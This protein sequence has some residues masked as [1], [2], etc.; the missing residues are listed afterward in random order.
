[1]IYQYDQALQLP[2]VDL[3]D[4]QMMAMALNAAKDMYERGEQQIK[5]F[6]K[7]YGDFLT[8][9]TADQNWWNQNVTGK[10]RDT[11]NSI[12]ARGGDPL[13]NARDRAQLSMMIN[14]MPYGDM[15]FKRQRAENAKEY[16]KNMATLRMNDKYNK[17]FSM[18]LQED[19]NQWALDSAG[20]TS[21]TVFSDLNTKTSH[22]FDGVNRK[23]Y[24]Y[25]KDGYDYFGVKPEDLKQVLNSQIPDF[26]NTQYGKYQ[27]ELARRQVGPNASDAEA[28]EQ[29]KKNIIDYN[30]E[31]TINP[32]REMNPIAALELKDKYEARKQD[33]EF[34]YAAALQQLKNAGKTGNGSRTGDGSGVDENGNPLPTP[35]HEQIKDSVNQKLLSS[36]GLS[37]ESKSTTQKSNIQTIIDYYQNKI[38][39]IEKNKVKQVQ[40]GFETVTEPNSQVTKYSSVGMPIP[41]FGPGVTKQVPKYKYEYDSSKDREYQ[42]YKTKLEHYKRVAN[43]EGDLTTQEQAMYDKIVSKIQNKQQLNKAEENILKHLNNKRTAFWTDYKDDFFRARSNEADAKSR[44]GFAKANDEFYGMFTFTPGDEAG[45]KVALG[46]FTEYASKAK[47][48]DLAGEYYVV[49]FNNAG[50]EY[51]PI[52]KANVSGPSRYKYNSIQNK[53]SEWLKSGQVQGLLLDESVQ[54]ATIPKEFSAPGKSQLDILANPCIEKQAFLDFFNTLSGKWTQSDLAEV[55]RQLGLVPVD[56]KGTILNQDKNGYNS[57]TYYKVPTIKTFDNAGGF[58]FGQMDDQYNIYKYGAATA[59]KNAINN[60]AASLTP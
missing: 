46:M 2:T 25:T 6:Q 19:P 11:I 7:A 39:Q 42:T 36:M 13:R 56:A 51:A 47:P 28:V 24:L 3:Y 5:D 27:L 21:P 22:W 43:G 40:D 60:E 4:T 18:F 32:T 53:F 58:Q 17:D 15:A 8:P 10:V 38:D 1:M 37:E 50:I 55:A 35:L 57:A 44:N 45:K 29:L 16:Y 30:R 12:Y 20:V 48:K 9:I 14:N 41:Q 52:R 49:N 54:F 59:Y 33:R 31:L 26:I 34:R 23:G